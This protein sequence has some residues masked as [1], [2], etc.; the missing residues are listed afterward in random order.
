MKSLTT[1]MI[2]ILIFKK[3]SYFRNESTESSLET[4][5]TLRKFDPAVRQ[6]LT[7]F[8]QYVAECMPKFVQ[9]VQIT[10]GDKITL[11]LLCAIRN[12]IQFN[13]I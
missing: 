4:R 13:T 9:K 1:L 7:D 3:Y 2:I 5:P 12:L 11:Y 6:N 10:A 8:G